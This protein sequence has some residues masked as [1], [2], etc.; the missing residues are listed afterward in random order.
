MADQRLQKDSPALL[1]VANYRPDVGFAWWLMESFWV[2][3]AYVARDLGWRTILVF[4]E[5]GVVPAA[6]RSAPIQVEFLDFPGAST[7]NRLEAMR[8]VRHN[9]VR[10]IY[11]TD[12]AYTAVSH[13]LMRLAGVRT[14]VVH[15]HTPGDRP[16]VLGSRG[17]AKDVLR[18]LPL[19]NA[20][21]QLCVSPLISRRAVEHAR[22]PPRRV[23]TVQN[24]IAPAP[25]IADRVAIRQAAGLPVE[26]TVCITASRAHPYKRIDFIIAVARRIVVERGRRDVVFAF[27]GDGPALAEL[28]ELARSKG[29]A[30]S[31]LF[32]GRRSDVPAL[33]RASDFALH[34]SQGE[35]FSLA[36]VEYMGAGLPAI[37]PDI[38]TVCQAIT[39][40]EEGIVY[41]DG[42]IE[43]A[44]A[45]V[46]ALADNAEQRRRMGRAAEARV[47][48]DYSLSDTHARLRAVMAAAIQ[49]QSLAPFSAN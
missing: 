17:L 31:F 27:C 11:Y 29:V 5:P 39:D 35:A 48:R 32:L 23:I 19:V 4:P 30:E 21:A 2:Q 10:A 18:R 34:P 47:A 28:Q 42:D 43:A 7:G 44:A 24:G 46:L 37:L 33:L 49:D 22:I 20:S 6:I 3:C 45:A 13:A 41:R 9:N 1:L 36:I 15:D 16:P 40:G 12:R 8:F 26:A 25:A 14:I 38:P